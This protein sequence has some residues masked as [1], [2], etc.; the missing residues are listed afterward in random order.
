MRF[1]LRTLATSTLLFAAACAAPPI[2]DDPDDPV[3]PGD[4]GSQP[5]TGRPITTT[6]QAAT[7]LGMSIM[8]S[9]AYG[10]PRMI[11]AIVQRT[12]A[13]NLAAGAAAQAH[14]AA[15]APLYVQQ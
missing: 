13:P 11:R 8:S 5:G 10:A 12:A 14:L 1:R 6:E 9:D 3:D 2:A 7:G 4:P 15:L